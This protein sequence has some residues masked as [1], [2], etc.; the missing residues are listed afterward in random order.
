MERGLREYTGN[1][2]HKLRTGH[3]RE[4]SGGRFH[5]FQTRFINL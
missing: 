2:E 1:S 4:R 3:L 5:C